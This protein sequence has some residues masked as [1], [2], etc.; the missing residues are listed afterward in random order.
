MSHPDPLERA[1][2]DHAGRAAPL[3]WV[4]AVPLQEHAWR[5]GWLHG[6]GFTEQPFSYLDVVAAPVKLGPVL[7]P[8]IAAGCLWLDGRLHR[9][10]GPS[11]RAS[12]FADSPTAARFELRGR[13]L[14]VEGEVGAP[15][16]RFVGWRYGHPGGGW[17][18]TVHCSIADMRL[19]VRLRSGDERTLSASGR[20]AYE[21]QLRPGAPAPVGLQPFADP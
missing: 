6:T 17:H 15:P 5:S 19:R 4:G 9:L 3:A 10:G 21:L 1:V 18:P 13:G 20:A 16:E 2:R 8:W 11:P 14:I 7:T 12:S